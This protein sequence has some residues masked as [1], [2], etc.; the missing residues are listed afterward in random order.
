MRSSRLPAWMT[1]AAAAPQ[2]R[3][4]AAD[5]AVWSG[6]KFCSVMWAVAPVGVHVR[7][8]QMRR[9]QP[10]ASCETMTLGP[11]SRPMWRMRPRAAMGGKD[12]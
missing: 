6:R 1:V 5:K 7:R 4:S 2:P 9:G 10:E 12:E 11:C 3:A 8:A